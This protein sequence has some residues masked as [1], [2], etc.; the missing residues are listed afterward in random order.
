M[1]DDFNID[2]TETTLILTEPAHNLPMIQT[3]TDQVIFEEYG[4]MNYYRALGASLVPWNSA[5]GVSTSSSTDRSPLALIVDCGFSFTHI[6][7]IVEGV[8]SWPN[9]KRINMGGKF[10]TNYLKELISF[11][12]YNMMDET[13]LINQIKEACCYVSTQFEKDLEASHKSK[14]NSIVQNYILPDYGQNKLGYIAVEPFD[15][16]SDDQ[17]L[18]LANER[19]VVPELIFSPSDI[20][21]K[22]AGIAETI[23]HS[24]ASFTED[25]QAMLLHNIVLAGGTCKFAGFQDRISRELQSLAPTSSLVRVIMP[26]DP[27]TCIWTGGADLACDPSSLNEV[28]VTLEEYAEYGSSICERKFG[29]YGVQTP[30]AG[31]SRAVSVSSEDF[32]EDE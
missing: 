20:G 10:L 29:R 28:T 30:T 11:R 1:F 26:Q 25:I 18:T 13:Y 15:K 32:N 16:D 9:V 2:P 6:I 14:L 8:V 4:F 23:M 7:P 21:L 31:N 24:I 19:F 5:L 27:Q 12:H 22:Q 17:V 3:A